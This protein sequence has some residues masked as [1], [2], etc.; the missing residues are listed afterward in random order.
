MKKSLKFL[1]LVLIWWF[2][3]IIAVLFLANISTANTVGN[4]TIE[5]KSQQKTQTIQ[6]TQ[7]QKEE[8]VIIV[9]TAKWCLYCPLLKK[10]F[11]A[12]SVKEIVKSNYDNDLHFI[13]IDQPENKL[14]VDYYNAKNLPLP[15]IFLLRRTE[16][17]K[18]I[19]LTYRAGYMSHILL[20]IF[21]RNPAK[22]DNKLDNSEN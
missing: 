10:S 8:Y 9:F 2:I 18:G 19:I 13:D 7:P 14:L 20:A 22:Y 21:L 12:K 11:E 1:I 4:I 15:S 17:N 5:T 6:K 3:F 16:K